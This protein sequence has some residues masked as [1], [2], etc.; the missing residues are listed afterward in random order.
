MGQEGAVC[1]NHKQTRLTEVVFPFELR[2]KI[3]SPRCVRFM[4]LLLMMTQSKYV[5]PYQLRFI[6]LEVF[7]AAVVLFN[8]TSPDQS[9]H[10]QVAPSTKQIA[11]LHH[12]LP[13]RQYCCP[14]KI[15]P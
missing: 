5:D 12:Q 1:T 11:Q 4:L 14:T 9:S 15:D 8:S 10:V 3:Y 13:Y 2:F 6:F 7:S